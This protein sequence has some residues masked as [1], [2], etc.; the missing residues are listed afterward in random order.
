MNTFYTVVDLVQFDSK[1][2]YEVLGPTPI[3]SRFYDLEHCLTGISSCHSSS[4]NGT[5]RPRYPNYWRR[6]H[7]GDMEA[8]VHIFSANREYAC[9]LKN[10][11]VFFLQSISVL[12]HI[13]NFFP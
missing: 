9:N 1:M 4:V 11:I 10:L 13:D 6:K 5:K 2:S 7:I 3:W 12:E 8:R